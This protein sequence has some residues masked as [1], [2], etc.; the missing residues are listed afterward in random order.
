LG[1]YKQDTVLCQVKKSL[2][3]CHG[4]KNSQFMPIILTR[5]PSEAR[6]D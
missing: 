2:A 6:G 1:E 5:C 3:A 4:T